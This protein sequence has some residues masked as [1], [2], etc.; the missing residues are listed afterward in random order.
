MSNEKRREKTLAFSIP[1]LFSSEWQVVI[2][3]QLDL[4]WRSQS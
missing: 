3:V 2:C 4:A 1:I